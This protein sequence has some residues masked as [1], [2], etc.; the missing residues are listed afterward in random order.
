MIAALIV[1]LVGSVA[2]GCAGAYAQVR[3]HVGLPATI[4]FFGICIT[5]GVA[6]STVEGG[7]AC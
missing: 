1:V 2:T 7:S 4:A 5:V 3:G 6:L